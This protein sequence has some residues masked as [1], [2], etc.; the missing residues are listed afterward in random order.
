ML[1]L[2]GFMKVVDTYINLTGKHCVNCKY[3]QFVTKFC[4]GRQLV[5]SQE[6]MKVVDIYKKKKIYIYIVDIK[7]NSMHNIIMF[8]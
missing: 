3:S 7:I 4:S 5:M 2:W 6:F 8:A 1:Q